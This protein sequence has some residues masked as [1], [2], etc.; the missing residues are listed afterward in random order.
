MA[1][2][3]KKVRAMAK[4][5]ETL[6]VE[7]DDTSDK[8]RFLMMVGFGKNKNPIPTIQIFRPLFLIFC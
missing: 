3:A 5:P 6:V 8:R 1:N 7:T 2:T 4:K